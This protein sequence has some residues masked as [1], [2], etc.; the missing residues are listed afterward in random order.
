MYRVSQKHENSVLLVPA[1][2]IPNLFYIQ[3]VP[4]HMGIQWRIGYRLFY[5]LALQYLISKAIIL[6]C[7]LEFILWSLPCSCKLQFSCF[8]K[9]NRMQSKHK[10]IV[11]I[12]DETLTDNS[13]LSRYHYTKSKNYVKRRYRI[14]HWIPIFIGTPCTE[15]EK[16]IL[17]PKVSKYFNYVSLKRTSSVISCVL[18]L[19]VLFSYL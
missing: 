15:F 12:A 6:F 13:F 11:K 1:S 5:E 17:N 10:Q 2:W 16:I 18:I 8:T 19:F 14:L 7:L 9:Y 3:G 4:K